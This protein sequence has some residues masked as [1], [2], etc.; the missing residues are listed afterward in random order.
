MR[1]AAGTASGILPQGKSVRCGARMKSVLPALAVA[2]FAMA[3]AACDG[4][5]AGG[6]CAT[7]EGVGVKITA[8]TDDIKKAQ[9]SGKIDA[10]R[11]GDIGGQILAAGSKFGGTGRTH[12][13]CMALDRIRKGAGL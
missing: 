11:A 10:A 8:L 12:D 5:A 6:A 7:V 9:L 1:L 13:Y 3:L 2:V 4:S